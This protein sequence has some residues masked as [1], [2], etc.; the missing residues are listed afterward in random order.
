MQE[1]KN[2][3]GV[4]EGGSR[5]LLWPVAFWSG[6][7]VMAFEL[8]GARLLMPAFGMGIEVWAVVIA[9]SLG[10]LAI[11]YGLGGKKI[12]ARP[13]PVT[14][15]V[16]LLLACLWLLLV[17]ILAPRI[18]AA[19]VGMSLVAG[20]CWSAAAILGV[21]MLLFGMVPPMLA[22]LLLGTTTRTG[23]V[24]GGLMAAGTAGSVF[25]TMLA[26]L[27][28]IPQLGVSRTLLVLAVGTGGFAVLVV[29]GSGLWKE[30]G[31]VTMI[32]AA[33]TCGSLLL[34]GKPIKAGPIRVLEEVE[35]VYGHL[36]VLEHHGT[37]ALVCNGVFQTVTPMSGLGITK[38]T[39]IRGRDYI[40]LIPYFRP[41][42]RD[43]LLIGVAGALHE[44]ALALYGIRVDGVEIEPA[45][46]PL[47]VK[48]FGLA[49]EVTVADGRRFLARC[50]GRFDAIILD[51]FVGGAVPEHLFT[52]EAF[53]LMGERLNDGGLLVVHVIG[54]PGHQSTRA[55]ARTVESAFPHLSA[56]RSGIGEELQHIYLFAAD[57]ALE[58]GGGERLELQDYGFTGQEFC[59]IE[60]EGA[61]LLTDDKSGLILL[62]S[63][64]L[65]EHRKHSRRLRRKPLW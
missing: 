46:I 1:P 23:T 63:D 39:L 36:E 40:E 38:G 7:A 16:A 19:F 50:Q 54:R 48:Y 29:A 53:E 51:A 22:R 45:M 10:A 33:V 64:I 55:V 4:I 28:L 32:A 57:K 49:A 15:A 62:S 26:G 14:P 43:V 12:D 61:A 65:A 25:G 5:L 37:R 35:G 42:C 56:I 2:K 31:L 17:R 8:A 13:G 18:T 30:A 27:V 20:A 59:R 34:K 58:L 9:A 24:V 41:G 60:S 44:Q 21:P 52:R 6:A 3:A 11:G 47:A